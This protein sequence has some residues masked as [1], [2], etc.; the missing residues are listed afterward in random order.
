[1]IGKQTFDFM[2]V[3]KKSSGSRKNYW[4]KNGMAVSFP[5]NGNSV[6]GKMERR[7][8]T[9][10]T[11]NTQENTAGLSQQGAPVHTQSHTRVIH[12][13]CSQITRLVITKYMVNLEV[14][15]TH[16]LIL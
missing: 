6:S 8:F 15:K 3:K 13:K 12:L 10:F 4:K 9:A 1:M 5:T 11:F 2:V 14:C 16:Y 7:D